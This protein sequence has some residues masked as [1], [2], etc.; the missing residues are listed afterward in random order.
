MRGLRVPRKRRAMPG[1]EQRK[2]EITTP[3]ASKRVVRI[4]EGVTV[5]DLARNMGVKAAEIIRK[6]MDLGV[7]ST[8]NQVLD[9]DTATFVAGEF[10]YSV[11]NVAFDVE[12]TIDEGEEVGPGE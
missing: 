9:V 6:L 11:D 7:M 2:T 3:R 1:K 12:S 10:G 8:L 4:T 5:G